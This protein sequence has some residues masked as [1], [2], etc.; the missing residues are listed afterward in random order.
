VDIYAFDLVGTAFATSHHRLASAYHVLFEK[1]V[2]TTA[3]ELTS[4]LQGMSCYIGSHATRLPLLPDMDA[5][6]SF[7]LHGKIRVTAVAGDFVEDWLVLQ[8]E[9]ILPMYFTVCPIDSLPNVDITSV[10]TRVVHCPVGKFIVDP[11]I[12]VLRPQVLHTSVV[13]ICENVI[14]TPNG[15]VTSSSGGVYI[16]HLGCAVAIHLECT[17]EIKS[18]TVSN[19][20]TAPVDAAP[21]T[22]VGVTT[23]S[24]Q[25]EK[26]LSTQKD[27]I[28]RL[29][30]AVARNKR[31]IKMM[32]KKHMSFGRGLIISTTEDLVSALKEEST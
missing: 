2:G 5:A 8:C 22:A 17:D 28:S 9:D 4:A 23:R 24:V 31:Y 13:E 21:S 6:F 30:T 16:D 25:F 1:D 26:Q 20:S 3:A 12:K 10:A 27:D 29:Q 11:A 15:L 18:R 32:A 7:A 19:D 14:E